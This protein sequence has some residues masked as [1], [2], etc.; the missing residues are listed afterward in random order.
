MNK[1]R[2]HGELEEFRETFSNLDKLND[3]MVIEINQFDI[4]KK[5]TRIRIHGIKNYSIWIR[6]RGK[7]IE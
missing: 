2:I 1:G 6:I 7:I 3:E 5:K 4:F